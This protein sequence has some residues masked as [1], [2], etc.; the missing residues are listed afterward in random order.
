M[1]WIGGFVA[2]W[3]A[4]N[5]DIR[6]DFYLWCVG[7]CY[8]LLWVVCGLLVIRLRGDLLVLRVVFVLRLWFDCWAFNS[9]GMILCAFIAC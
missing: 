8:R 9:V 4:L 2:C 6:F 5:L 3:V 7:Y 1:L